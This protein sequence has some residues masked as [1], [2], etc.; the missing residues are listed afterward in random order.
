L[1]GLGNIPGGLTKEQSEAVIRKDYETFAA[2][3]KAAGI[4]PVK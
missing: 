4:A 2:A 3:I 1:S